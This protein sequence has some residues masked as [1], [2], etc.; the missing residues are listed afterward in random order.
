MR[1]H[2][3]FLLV[4]VLEWLSSRQGSIA[5]C[6]DFNALGEAEEVASQNIHVDRLGYVIRV[7]PGK[8]HVCI[9]LMGTTIEGLTSEN[10]AE[11]AVVGKAND[12]NNLVHGPP[13]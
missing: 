3:N 9:D 2:H 10:A 11:S 12:L 5:T 1:I 7:V 4:G 6:H 8:D 13:V